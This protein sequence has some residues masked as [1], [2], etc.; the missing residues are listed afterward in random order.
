MFDTV[1]YIMY[2]Y[3]YPRLKVLKSFL[4]IWSFHLCYAVDIRFYISEFCDLVM[5]MH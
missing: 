5:L 3:D 2:I 4:H 1:I